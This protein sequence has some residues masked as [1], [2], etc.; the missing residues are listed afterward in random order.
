L[1]I[2]VISDKF[3]SDEAQFVVTF[4]AERGLFEM[5]SRVVV[6]GSRPDYS[7]QE[8]CTLD[9]LQDTVF[10]YICLVCTDET[11]GKYIKG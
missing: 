9:R 10:N 6:F 11:R 5:Y 1:S 2:T 7:W 3:S 8:S 4:N